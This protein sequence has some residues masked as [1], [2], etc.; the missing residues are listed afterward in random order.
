MLDGFPLADGTPHLARQLLVQWSK[1]SPTDKSDKSESNRQDPNCE[2][3][4]L[5]QANDGPTLN[6]LFPI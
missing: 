6:T 5:P 1:S 4:D 3:Y 2:R